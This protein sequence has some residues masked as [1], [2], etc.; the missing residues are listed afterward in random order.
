MLFRSQQ[1]NINAGTRG[2]AETLT[3]SLRELLG[4]QIL[5]PRPV[6]ASAPAPRP[7]ARVAASAS[8]GTGTS[9]TTGTKAPANGAGAAA[10]TTAASRGSSN[11]FDKLK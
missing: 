8:T 10:S 6:E 3:R 2:E 11:P 9:G 1:N 4:E 5:V 7:R